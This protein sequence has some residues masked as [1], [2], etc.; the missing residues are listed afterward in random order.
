MSCAF[1]TSF[2]FNVPLRVVCQESHRTDAETWDKRKWA[3]D[4]QLL[5]RLILLKC[6]CLVNRRMRP[7]FSGMSWRGLRSKI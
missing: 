4:K 5:E 6:T 2:S 7:D 3:I 1:F